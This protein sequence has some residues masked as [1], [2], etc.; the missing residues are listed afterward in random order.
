MTST[1]G[2]EPGPHWRGASAPYS[3]L[4]K[5]S[6]VEAPRYNT[7]SSANILTEQCF[8][9]RGGSLIYTINNRGPW[10]DPCGT[11]EVTTSSSE[12]WE[13]MHMNCFL[14]AKLKMTDKGEAKAS[15]PS[16]GSPW[17]H[18]FRSP[19]SLV[20]VRI[21]SRCIFIPSFGRIVRLLHLFCH[22]VWPF[23]LAT[24]L[25]VPLFNATTTDLRYLYLMETT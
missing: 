13:S 7:V 25:D 1:P 4:L 24:P 23:E 22:S 2:F 10:M 5:V 17:C 12:D 9:Q 3:P 8:T 18:N 15:T 16:S 6:T 20:S 19:S 11:P 14:P 21:L